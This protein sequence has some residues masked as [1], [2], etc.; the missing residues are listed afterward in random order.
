VTASGYEVAW[1][2]TGVD[3]Y[4]VWGT[5]S[6]GNYTGNLVPGVS[7]SSV[8]LEAVEPSFQQDLNGDGVIGVTLATTVIEQHGSTDLVQVGNNYF[9]YAHGTTSGPELMFNGA[10]VTVGQAS[11]WAPIGAE[12]TASGYEVAWKETGVDLYSVWGTNSGG[13]YTGNLVPG[14]SGSSVALESVEPSFQQDLN[15]DGVI[16]VT[17]HTSTQATAALIGAS[18]ASAVFKSTLDMASNSSVTAQPSQPESI[19]QYTAIGSASGHDNVGSSA[20][21]PI[22]PNLPSSIPSSD[23]HLV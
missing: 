9:L 21:D 4:S 15:G 7:G 5:N 19:D 13:N 2:E 1:K 11:G 8:P 10:P 18:D 23:W 3:L 20:I 6:G 12:V 22:H 16:G 17:G 14:V